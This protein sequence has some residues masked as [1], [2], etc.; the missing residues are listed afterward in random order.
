MTKRITTEDAIRALEVE[1]PRRGAG[2]NDTGHEFNYYRHYTIDGRL[3]CVQLEACSDLP[4]WALTTL[5]QTTLDIRHYI[6]ARDRGY[7]E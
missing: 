2:S 1:C 4:P 5:A 3:C 7:N 6:D